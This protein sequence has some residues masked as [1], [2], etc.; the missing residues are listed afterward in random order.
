MSEITTKNKSVVE[1][2]SSLFRIIEMNDEDC[3]FEKEDIFG[4]SINEQRNVKNQINNFYVYAEGRVYLKEISKKW[5]EIKTMDVPAPRKFQSSF[6]YKNSLYILG[7]RALKKTIMKDFCKL[8]LETLVWTKLDTFNYSIFGHTSNVIKTKDQKD[9]LIVFG[10]CEDTNMYDFELEQ[11]SILKTNKQPNPRIFHTS[12]VH[13]NYLYIHGGKSPEDNDVIYSDF[14]RLNLVE[15]EWEEIVFENDLNPRYG[16]LN[17]ISDN[18][19]FIYGG[20]TKLEDNKEKIFYTSILDIKLGKKSI[21]NSS[22]F[23]STISDFDPSFFFSNGNLLHASCFV[24]NSN[25]YFFSQIDTKTI[26]LVDEDLKTIPN[27]ILQITNIKN[28]DLKHN[29]IT[30]KLFPK[31]LNFECLKHLNLSQ[32]NLTEYPTVLNRIDTLI[33][34][35]LSQNPIE[36]LSNVSLKNLEI[37]QM[38]NCQLKKIQKL[39]LPKLKCGELWKNKLTLFPEGIE[40]IEILNISMNKLTN[41]KGIEKCTKLKILRVNFNIFKE[42]PKQILNLTNLQELYMKNCKTTLMS[43]EINILKKLK[44]LVFIEN[45]IEELPDSLSELSNLESLNI[46]FN[47]IKEIP[48]SIG[49]LTNLKSFY[50][51][52]N[53][54]TY[55]PNEMKHLINLEIFSCSRN[56]IKDISPLMHLSKMKVLHFEYNRVNKIPKDIQYLYLLDRL[57]C[58]HNLIEEIPVEIGKLH[59]LTR[60]YISNN[61]WNK[62]PVEIGGLKYL[63]NFTM[64]NQNLEERFQGKKSS[65]ILSLLR[66]EFNE[67]TIKTVVSLKDVSFYF[68]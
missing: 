29:K 54:L 36:K 51:Q 21:W 22:P 6:L 65:E 18:Y 8:D 32:N 30:T 47:S 2:F 12:I 24:E 26:Q 52:K 20:L 19:Y 10:M 13:E 48:S 64:L 62:I 7:G 41:L 25:L 5:V 1:N 56:L 50:C 28:L 14:W 57:Y 31:R 58:E 43:K 27:N 60:L 53:Q 67:I 40:T 33:E 42:F 61:K 3:I 37:L 68:K 59:W 38:K 9:K 11:W 15:M 66:K 63:Q 55:L 39:N 17:F 45:E 46:S 23:E 4:Y 44:I 34:L 35:D 16:H 49:K